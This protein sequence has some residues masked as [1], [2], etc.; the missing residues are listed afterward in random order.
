MGFERG[1]KVRVERPDRPLALLP[2]QLSLDDHDTFRVVNHIRAEVKAG[3]D[4]RPGL[5]AAAA[6]P[7]TAPRPW[8][9]DAF[10]VP[11]LPDD[12]VL[13]YDFDDEEEAGGGGG[14]QATSSAPPPT[15]LAAL[16]AENDALRAALASLAAATLDPEAAS[17]LPAG[18]AATV[19]EFGGG[20]GGDAPPSASD[21]DPDDTPT[22]RADAAYFDSYSSM[23]IHRE[24]LA[25]APRTVAYRDALEKNP[26]T[27]RGAAVL[28]VGAG[29]GVLSMFAARAGAK[30]VVA[31]EASE[32]MAGLA[33]ANAAANG[34]SITVAHARVEELLSLPGLPDGQTQVDV[35]VSEW[36]GYA[37][38]FECMLDA[39]L[40][41]RDRF[42]R[43]GGAL[44]PD[45]VSVHVAGVSEVA[46]DLGFWKDVQGLDL[47]PCAAAARAARRSAGAVL[48]VNGATLLTKAA[49]VHELDLMVASAGDA[50]FSTEFEV[51]ATARGAVAAVALW[52]DA[53]FTARVC[54]DYPVTLSTA[55]TAPQ[56]HW[57]Q[58]VLEL[59]EAIDVSPGG[60]GGAATLL[61]GRVSLA[62]AP[63]HRGVDVSLEVEG[64]GADGKRVGARAVGLFPFVMS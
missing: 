18:V 14:D 56:T 25:D 64:V 24:M 28:D 54:P 58:A 21:S 26:T 15:D 8:A 19:G 23:G 27:L 33:R 40:T 20:G 5:A 35:I 4:P 39:V 6:A 16:R 48:P 10:L 50:A 37:L 43:P 11:V 9:G 61:R 12:A 63:S 44:L 53:R 55:P 45:A 30:A 52:F 38:F 47:A 1:A 31:V 34:I 51:A 32:A 17:M 13:F 41:A 42:L 29:T 3:R 49:T 36:M 62:R 7:A 59:E 57:H 22:A 2:P 60:E 46:C